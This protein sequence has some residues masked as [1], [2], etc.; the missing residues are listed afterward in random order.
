MGKDALALRSRVAV[1]GESGEEQRWR[2]ESPHIRSRAGSLFNCQVDCPFWS[3]SEG[4]LP[5][6]ARGSGKLG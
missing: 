2:K 3:E 4:A 5:D 1:A 6:Q